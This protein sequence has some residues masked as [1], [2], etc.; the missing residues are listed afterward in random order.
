M[1][2]P[3]REVCRDCGGSRWEPFTA[4]PCAGCRGTGFV[5]CYP[6]DEEPVLVV[7]RIPVEG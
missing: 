3:T 4:L 1:D 7:I 2:V 5:W 6:A